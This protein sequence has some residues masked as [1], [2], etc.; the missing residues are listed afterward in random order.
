M[1]MHTVFSSV[2]KYVL[3]EWCAHTQKQC[4]YWCMNYASVE[5]FA[6]CRHIDSIVFF[7]CFVFVMCMC[8]FIMIFFCFVDSLFVQF[9][10]LRLH[11]LFILFSFI[12]VIL[13]NNNLPEFNSGREEE[14]TRG[15]MGWCYSSQSH[16]WKLHAN[17]PFEKWAQEMKE[18]WRKLKRE[19]ANA[20]GGWAAA[21]VQKNVEEE[22][23]TAREQTIAYFI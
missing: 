20:R 18:N 14:E 10:P 3:C 2:L 8:G 5:C 4:V 22:D 19:G 7:F 1:M 15:K 13:F 9:T 21:E 6:L 11:T 12:L 17:R 16:T 23:N